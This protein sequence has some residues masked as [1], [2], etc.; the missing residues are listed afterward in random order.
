MFKPLTIIKYISYSKCL[1]SLNIEGWLGYSFCHILKQNSRRDQIS[2][3]SELRLRVLVWTCRV[4]SDI[5]L[6]SSWIRWSSDLQ[7]LCYHNSYCCCSCYF[8]NFKLDNNYNS[9][10]FLLITLK[11]VMNI[12]YLILK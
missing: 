7:D 6:Q 4:H 10:I 12:E 9:V 5:A 3:R 8:T 1:I 2:L 11:F